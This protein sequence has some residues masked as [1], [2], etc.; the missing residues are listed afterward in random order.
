MRTSGRPS[1]V[2]LPTF[3]QKFQKEFWLPKTKQYRCI[4]DP[5]NLFL[6]LLQLVGSTNHDGY[7]DALMDI[8]GYHKKI[9]SKG[10]LSKIRSKVSFMF[11]ENEFSKL[12][13]GFNNKRFNFNGY[14]I[15]AIDGAQWNLPRTNDVIKN[16]YTGKAI[17]KYRAGYLPKMYVTHAWD[18]LTGVTKDVLFA[19]Y[20]DEPLDARSMVKNFEKNSITLYDR[21][22]ISIDMIEAHR[23][24]ENF[25]IMRA[26]K[27]F[28]AVKRLL[29]SEDT[30]SKVRIGSRY[31]SLF[32]VKNLKTAETDVFATNLKEDWVNEKTISELYFKRWEVEVSFKEFSETL[33]IEQWHSKS[34]N[35]ILQEF[36]VGFWLINYSRIQ[37]A[38][39][40]KPP[41]NH[42][43]RSYR[44]PN[45]KLILTQFLRQMKNIFQGKRSLLIRLHT[46]VKKTTERRIHLSR[47]YPRIV[48]SPRSH[49]PY[50]GW[51]WE[52]S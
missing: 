13:Q 48:K 44:K 31:V 28:N 32:K 27:N 9:P 26:R 51:K 25:F 34:M 2:N 50:Y 33:K 24:A 1:M 43:E 45:Y 49:Y 4:L 7:W 40:S 20:L 37:I 30:K 6:T 19:P 3:E 14:Q 36:Y 8:F 38:L 18:V 17:G 41:A 42:F 35:G 22:Y 11:F 5:K 12:I 23:D 52:I 16:L 15:Y 47:Q 39:R 21:L 29:E 46:I 10:T